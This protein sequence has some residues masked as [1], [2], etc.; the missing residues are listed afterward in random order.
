MHM[1]IIDHPDVCLSETVNPEGQESGLFNSLALSLAEQGPSEKSTETAAPAQLCRDSP[2]G[3]SH[4]ALWASVSPTTIRCTWTRG[5]LKSHPALMHYENKGPKVLD[6][7]LFMTCVGNIYSG[8]GSARY[9]STAP[10]S[11]VDPPLRWVKTLQ[12]V[13]SAVG[14]MLGWLSMM[15]NKE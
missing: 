9:H 1:V 4:S 11:G 6:P 3:P 10:V 15:D 2:C 14:C 13:F 8:S 12:W 5:S 7:R